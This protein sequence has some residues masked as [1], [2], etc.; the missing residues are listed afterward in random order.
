[1]YRNFMTVGCLLTLGVTAVAAA[2]SSVEWN[3]RFDGVLVTPHEFATDPATSLDSP[4]LRVG[5]FVGSV[6]VALQGDLTVTGSVDGC[7]LGSLNKGK[8]IDAPQRDRSTT[9]DLSRVLGELD[10]AK[11]KVGALSV[12][13]VNVVRA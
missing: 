10:G 5:S 8:S 11:L 13:S 2:Q 7:L 1:M 6:E 9:K 3:R 4:G 12:V